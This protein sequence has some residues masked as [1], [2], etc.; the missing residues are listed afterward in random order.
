VP[1]TATL[2]QRVKKLEAERNERR[3][4]INWRF[5]ARDAR[6]KL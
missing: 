6:A 1:D 5:T 2:Q 4:S 3:A